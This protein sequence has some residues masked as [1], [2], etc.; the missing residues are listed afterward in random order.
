MVRH[1]RPDDLRRPLCTYI[2]NCNHREYAN[3]CIEFLDNFSSLK[4]WRAQYPKSNSYTCWYVGFNYDF[5]YEE[6]RY[7]LNFEI[8]STDI[9]IEFRYPQYLPRKIREYLKKN[10]TWRTLLFTGYSENN[11]KEMMNIYLKAIKP[12]FDRDR[13]K[14]GKWHPRKKIGYMKA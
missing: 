4:V 8:R 12:D 5:N 1:E 9:K 14:F 11:L 2:C 6:E 7:I 3:K 13:R 10:L